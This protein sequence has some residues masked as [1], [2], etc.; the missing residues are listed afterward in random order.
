MQ[1]TK[2]PHASEGHRPEAESKPMVWER[3]FPIAFVQEP[4]ALETSHELSARGLFQPACDFCG[5][6]AQTG[7]ACLRRHANLRFARISRSRAPERKENAI[8]VNSRRFA[9]GF[10]SPFHTQPHPSRIGL[11]LTPRNISSKKSFLSSMFYTAS[12]VR[13][14]K[15]NYSFDSSVNEFGL[16]FG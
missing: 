8:R 5:G 2:N 9:V 7:K 13:G 4:K 1:D 6:E 14:K 12:N 11:K 3:V 16:S 15:R 10:I